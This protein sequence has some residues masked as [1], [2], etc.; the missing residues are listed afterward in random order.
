M[1]Y[2]LVFLLLLQFFIFS[3]LT[4]KPSKESIIN[5]YKKGNINYLEKICDG[6]INLDDEKLKKIACDYLKILTKKKLEKNI[7]E[8]K[9]KENIFYLNN[10][11]KGKI[12]LYGN[13][14]LIKRASSYISHIK[15]KGIEKNI[16]EAY[17]NENIFY[18]EKIIN[19]KIE[20]F[21][22]K[23]LIKKSENYLKII[24]R[25][26]ID[27]Y[28]EK[29]LKELNENYLLNVIN[30]EIKLYKN[31]D[32]IKKSENY[33]KIIRRKTLEK[34]IEDAKKNE[35]LAFLESIING[36]ENI[37]NNEDLKKKSELYITQIK[38][39]INKRDEEKK[40]K[41][42]LNKINVAIEKNDVSFLVDISNN[43]YDD[44]ME[45]ETKLYVE[46]YL[47]SYMIIN[48]LNYLNQLE[49]EVILEM[50]KARLNPKNYA[51]IKIKKY[52]YNYSHN[53]GEKIVNECYNFLLK[54]K[55]INYLLP[56]YGMTLASKD[57]VSDQSK[58]GNTGHDGSDKSDP[59]SR[60]KR[61]GY[62][63]GYAGEN[64]SYGYNNAESIILQLLIDDGVPSRGHRKNIMNS[65]YKL[66]GV[67][68]GSHLKYNYMCLINYA[69][70]YIDY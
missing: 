1:K 51:E 10:I 57:H 21:G 32:L 55:P 42:F 49:K 59:F 25:K 20:L 24:F 14:D 60:M 39:I 67:S 61:Y 26:K 19:E 13:D 9:K 36:N 37:Y 66:S 58:T 8:A 22:N 69:D 53:E 50:N 3:C 6:N 28:I 38:Q 15:R 44:N 52:G 18:L 45:L 11:V 68:C 5:A 65:N 34:K 63:F 70:N 43:K 23:D 31:D 41:E 62:E 27:S 30:G 48:G 40:F 54:Q 56:S 7:E 64:I 47:E 4:L 16:N 29:S 12:K 2:K 46:K 35:N 17:K 33:L